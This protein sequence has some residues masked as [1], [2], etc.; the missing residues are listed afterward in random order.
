M[1]DWPAGVGRDR[2]EEV[3]STNAEALR[4]A[5]RGDVG[6]AWILARRQ[7]RGRG[8]RGRRW[9]DRPGNFYG[10]FLF[11]PPGEPADAALRSFTASLAL[12]DALSL[13]TGRPQ[14]FSLK[15]PNDVLLSGRKLAGILLEGCATPPDMPHAL[16]IGIGVNLAA[17]PDVAELE[18]TALAPVSLAEATGLEVPPEEF[19]DLLA[20]AFDHWEGRMQAEGF[21]AIRTAWLAR[22]ARLGERVVARLPGREVSGVFR[23]LDD[24]GAILLETAEGRVALPA[25]EIF[26]DTGSCSGEAGH[27]ARH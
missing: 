23:T 3:D 24:S 10:T 12:Y 15:W 21:G 20:P 5:A 14:L 8:R 17:R 27:A 25:A 19:L 26:F 1:Q 13:V 7:T 18:A 16:A 4:R 11:V 2:L 9:S 22:A 6:P